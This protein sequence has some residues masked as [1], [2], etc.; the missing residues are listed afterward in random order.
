MPGLVTERTLEKVAAEV[1]TP[2]IQATL[3]I[4]YMMQK[5]PYAFPILGGRKGK[6]HLSTRRFAVR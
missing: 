5:T 2:N 3:V 6:S 1:G 4:A